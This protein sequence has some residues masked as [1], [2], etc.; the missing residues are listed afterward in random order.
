MNLKSINLLTHNDLD[1]AACAIVTKY[2]ADIIGVPCHVTMTSN[3]DLEKNFEVWQEWIS[4]GA[5]GSLNIIS[6]LPLGPLATKF[7]DIKSY[8][9]THERIRDDNPVVSVMLIDHHID[10][11][12]NK[13][14][15]MINYECATEIESNTGYACKTCAALLVWRYFKEYFYLDIDELYEFVSLVRDWDTHAYPATLNPLA[16][17][18]NLLYFQMGVEWFEDYI[19]DHVCRG[20]SLSS[21]DPTV[22]TLC[23]RLI[24]TVSIEVRK[25]S[26]PDLW[27]E[28]VIAG[29]EVL[30]TICDNKSLYSDLGATVSEMR[31][32][33]C[34]M[35]D[36]FGT[37]SLRSSGNIDCNRIAKI[38]GGGGHLNAAGCRIS[39]KEFRAILNGEYANH[40][41]V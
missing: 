17:R 21:M 18:Y 14:L 6:D 4:V 23:N 40:K 2:C 37:C 32:K 38:F 15:E 5:E 13:A 29:T 24:N 7:R 3:A 11:V 36:S 20:K 16:Q 19:L 25:R 39:E 30:I 9:I 8:E 22:E 26:N 12:T 31:G 35:V 27:K 34:M 10:S 1:G 41:V 28:A 33:A